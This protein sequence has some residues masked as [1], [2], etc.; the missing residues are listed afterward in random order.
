MYRNVSPKKSKNFRY[1]DIIISA[2]NFKNFSW[3]IDPQNFN[4]SKKW[5]ILIG[6]SDRLIYPI[7]INWFDPE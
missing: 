4:R 1:F 6:I 2:V 3:L 7:L 5:S